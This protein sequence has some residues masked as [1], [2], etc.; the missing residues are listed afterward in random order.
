[1]ANVFNGEV[2][3]T[4]VSQYYRFLSYFGKEHT[5]QTFDDRGKNRKLVRQ[6]HGTIKEHFHELAELNR[7]GAGIFFTVNET[8][9]MGRS[10]KHIKKNKSSL[11][12]PRWC[13]TPPKI[14]S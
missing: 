8:D 2:F 10:T 11:Y 1:M 5:F 12:R 9:L 13:A 6:F 7:Q 4:N 3:Y 14:F